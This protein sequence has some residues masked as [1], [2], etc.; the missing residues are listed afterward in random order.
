MDNEVTLESLTADEMRMIT[1][2]WDTTN[3]RRFELIEKKTSGSIT[4]E[5]GVELAHLQKLVGVIRSEGLRPFVEKLTSAQTCEKARRLY[6]TLEGCGNDL[7][8]YSWQWLKDH[9]E[10]CE[11]CRTKI[12]LPS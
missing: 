6:N 1:S 5:Q 11:S 9:L 7:A 12:Q 4:P 3:R 8:P 10:S 2:D